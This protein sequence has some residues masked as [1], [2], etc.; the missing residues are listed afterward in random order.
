MRAQQ[1]FSPAQV[2]SPGAAPAQLTGISDLLNAIMPLM[3]L[4]MVFAMMVPM[5]KGMTKGISA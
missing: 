4:A 3:M 1:I 2:Y 5:M